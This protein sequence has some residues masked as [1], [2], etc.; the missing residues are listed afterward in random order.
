M[1][2]DEMASE[3]LTCS[4]KWHVLKIVSNSTRSARWVQLNHKMYNVRTNTLNFGIEINGTTKNHINNSYRRT[5]GNIQLNS[6][7]ASHFKS[8][9]LKEIKKRFQFEHNFFCIP[10]FSDIP[11]NLIN[12]LI[13]LPEMNKRIPF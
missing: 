2:I 6:I 3:L 4:I 10:L 5:N 9:S 8:R 12:F 7:S 1:A 11:L 13:A